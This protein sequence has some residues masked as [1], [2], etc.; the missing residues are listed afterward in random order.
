MV[1][2]AGIFSIFSK[3]ILDYYTT[4]IKLCIIWNLLHFDVRGYKFS[5]MFSIFNLENDCLICRKSTHTKDIYLDF[6]KAPIN[7]IS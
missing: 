7:L 2:Y 3:A 1:C 5:N 6:M 4:L